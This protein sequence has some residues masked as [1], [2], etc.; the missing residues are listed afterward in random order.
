MNTVI[1]LVN[2]KERVLR[3]T[4]DIQSCSAIINDTIS[5]LEN[6]DEQTEVREIISYLQSFLDRFD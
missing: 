6:Y 2:I 1:E 3:R 4:I 5:K